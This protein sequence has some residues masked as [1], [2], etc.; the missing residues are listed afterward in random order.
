MNALLS[1]AANFS[2]NSSAEWLFAIV[3]TLIAVVAFALYRLYRVVYRP[4]LDRE[5]G[6]ELEVLD[7]EETRVALLIDLIKIHQAEYLR[8]EIGLEVA[9]Q[10]QSSLVRNAL[11]NGSEPLYAAPVLY[12]EKITRLWSAKELQVAV[13]RALRELDL[14]IPTGHISPRAQAT[15]S[16]QMWAKAEAFKLYQRWEGRREAQ[17][18]ERQ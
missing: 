18:S 17:G 5:S 10:D 11:L 15:S 4:D 16:C 12:L 1:S 8:Y 13:A 9:R 14:E 6:S 3:A 2:D 7:P